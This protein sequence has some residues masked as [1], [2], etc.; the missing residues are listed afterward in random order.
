VFPTPVL[1]G[2]PHPPFLAQPQ[3]WN[4][5]WE[6]ARRNLGP[7]HLRCLPGHRHNTSPLSIACCIRCAD[8]RAVAARSSNTFAI[9]ANQ[10]PAVVMDK[11]VQRRDDPPSPAP[12]HARRRQPAS[13]PPSLTTASQRH[14]VFQARFVTSSRSLPRLLA[15]A[16]LTAYPLPLQVS[17]ATTLPP[18]SSRLRSQPRGPRLEA[19]RDPAAPPSRTSLPSL[20]VELARQA[21]FR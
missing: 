5:H 7:Q 14:G 9:M 12:Q 15:V 19:A 21:T 4:P 10:T 11:Y 1:G 17:P 13:S 3:A 16:P 8:T 18:S 2:A 20:P 6:L